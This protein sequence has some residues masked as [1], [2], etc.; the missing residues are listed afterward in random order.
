MRN[1]IEKKL[2]KKNNIICGID[3]V[4]RGAL[5][6]PVGA[7]AV[8]L[9]KYTKIKGIDDSKKL[10]PKKRK[11]LY[12]K[13][14]DCA[15]SVGIG[16]ATNLEIDKLGIKEA[17][18]LAMKR[19]IQNLSLQPDF[20]LVDG[21]KISGLNSPQMALPKGESKSIS[22]AAASIVAKVAR[23]EYMNSLAKMFP[24]Y[25]F[26]RNKGYP[27]IQHKTALSRLGETPYHRRSFSPLKNAQKN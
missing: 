26:E 9:P 25:G 6:G 23:D 15:T 24:G 1:Y 7:A 8:I 20:F 27:T 22:I 17:T 19:A 13:I 16:Y 3:E 18:F 14:L 10:T 12:F 21:F 5:A 2:W 11:A 4:G